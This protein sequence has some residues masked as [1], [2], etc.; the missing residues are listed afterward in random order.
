MISQTLQ[1]RVRYK[2]SLLALSGILFVLLLS[3]LI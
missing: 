2:I 3:V 1:L